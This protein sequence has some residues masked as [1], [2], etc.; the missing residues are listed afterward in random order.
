MSHDAVSALLGEK[1]TDEE[2]RAA[3]IQSIQEQILE[4]LNKVKE[5][6]GVDT[7]VEII[8]KDSEDNE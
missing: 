2:M 4:I 6:V 7:P 5:E 1:M 8:V 3:Y